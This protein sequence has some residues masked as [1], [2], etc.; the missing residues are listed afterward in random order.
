MESSLAVGTDAHCRE[1][2]EKLIQA[3]SPNAF[4]NSDDR[5]DPPKCHE[6]TRVSI[7]NKVME[8][9]TGTIDTDAFMFWLNGPA[10]AGKTAIARTAAER[11]AAH[12][13]LLASFFFFR[14]DSKR[15]T[16]MPLVATIAYCVARI[17]PGARELINTTIETDPLI[18]SCSVEVQFI[19]LVMKPVQFLV[20]H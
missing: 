16:M 12:G 18:F 5:P 17:I 2:F 10:G 19:T 8:W 4:H 11:C 6:N 14:W 13:F 3:V 20:D 15:N 1:G 7:L 9:V